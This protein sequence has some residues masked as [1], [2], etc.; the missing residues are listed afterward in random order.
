MLA[1]SRELGKTYVEV[2]PMFSLLDSIIDAQ[3]S[4]AS[5]L[6]QEHDAGNIRVETAAITQALAG[7]AGV[8]DAGEYGISAAEVQ[9]RIEAAATPEAKE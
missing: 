8:W 2:L 3:E 7:A 4:G 1:T 5:V 6:S 9:A